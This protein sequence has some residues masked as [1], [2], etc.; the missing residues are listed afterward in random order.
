MIYQIIKKMEKIR[1]QYDYVKILT[2]RLGY[3]LESELTFG[4]EI[5]TTY[6][7]QEVYKL[8]KLIN[9]YNKKELQS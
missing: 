9:T 6:L 3:A 2:E 8:K 7:H 5:D 4:A 1:Q